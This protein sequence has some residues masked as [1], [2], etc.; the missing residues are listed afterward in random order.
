[1]DV[2]ARKLKERADQLGIS[3]AEA[4]RRCELDERRYGH[5]ASGR[6]EP[7][8]ATLTKIARAREHDARAGELGRS[9]SGDE[10]LASDPRIGC[11]QSKD[12]RAAKLK[13]FGIQARALAESARNEEDDARIGERRRPL[14]TL[15]TNFG[16]FGAGEGISNPRPQPWQ[17]CALPLS[18][19]RAPR[20]WRRCEA[21]HVPQIDSHCK[22]LAQHRCRTRHGAAGPETAS[23]SWPFRD[24]GLS[25]AA[26][27]L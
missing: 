9:S 6:R 14:V 13:T 16:K 4:A 18:Y 21:A 23:L 7:D 2:F 1:M 20:P 8:L 24:G 19:T 25:R 12:A 10:E 22:S 27:A 5:Y 11:I 3:S 15:P 26:P 17:G